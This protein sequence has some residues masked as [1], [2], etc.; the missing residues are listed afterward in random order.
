MV[1]SDH[2]LRKAPNLHPHQI[3]E[4]FFLNQMALCEASGVLDKTFEEINKIKI[5]YKYNFKA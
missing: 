5:N 4:Q 1:E 2:H 3:Q